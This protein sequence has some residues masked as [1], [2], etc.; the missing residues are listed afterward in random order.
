MRDMV[1]D[2]TKQ[3]E[4]RDEN[5]RRLEMGAGSNFVTQ[6]LREELED[7]RSENR[8]LKDQVFQL[9]RELNSDTQAQ[10]L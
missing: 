1:D 4:L 6:Q 7:V 8:S 10:K 5:I 3:L 9:N 2:Y